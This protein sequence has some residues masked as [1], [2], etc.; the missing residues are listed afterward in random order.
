MCGGRCTGWID[1]MA[2][3][4]FEFPGRWVEGAGLVLGPVL[5][6][7]GVLLRVDFDD[8]FPGQLAAFAANPGR[9]TASYSAFAA[10]NVLLWPA[11]IAL[12][13]RAWATQPRWALWGGVMVMLGLFAR[14]FHTGINHLIFQ[15]AGA[16]GVGGRKAVDGYY[17]AFHVLQPL[18]IAIFF[19]WVVLAVGVW[20]AGVLGIVRS[21]ALA[22]MSAL[23]IG[24]L[25]GTGP[26]SIVATLGLCVA[27]V[28]LGTR[29]LK[30]G[31]A[32]RWWAYPLAL[33]VGTAAVLLGM[34]G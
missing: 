2:T 34:A 23:P 10:G 13:R 30:D 1:G 26:M 18:S 20:R 11:V 22:S 29:I 31:P 15:I 25:K 28:P 5:M 16:Q 6:L 24:V 4:S 32:P 7:A 27:L 8:F 14:A 12:V 33:G 17:G 9:M 21:L 19:G 3:T